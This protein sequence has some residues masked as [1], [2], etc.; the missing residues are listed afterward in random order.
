MVEHGKW[1]LA[2]WRACKIFGHP[3]GRL[4][5]LE[6]GRLAVNARDLDDKGWLIYLNG[7]MAIKGLRLL[8]DIYS[9]GSFTLEREVAKG[10]RWLVVWTPTTNTI[11]FGVYTT[12]ME[13]YMFAVMKSGEVMLIGSG[14]DKELA[15][16]L[17]GL[18]AELV[19]SKIVRKVAKAVGVK[20]GSK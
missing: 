18:L 9:E 7:A 2:F 19:N 8:D 11:S 10:K 17:V 15:G 5:E 20:D 13:R 3:F 4:D 16:E 6:V 12:G 1:M 14:K